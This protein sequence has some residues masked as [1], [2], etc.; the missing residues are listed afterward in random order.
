MAHR[1][2]DIQQPQGFILEDVM[3]SES[4]WSEVEMH[5]MSQYSYFLPRSVNR[6]R[7]KSIFS[8]VR[9]VCFD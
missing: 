2:E 8:V 5:E 4:C 6:R 9:T 1:T 7:L 3:R